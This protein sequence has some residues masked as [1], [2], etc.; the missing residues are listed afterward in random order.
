[1]AF[2]PIDSNT[3]KVGDPITSDTITLIKNNFDDHELRI[4]SLATS[5]GTVFIINGDVSF[6]G[7]NISNPSIFYYKAR[8]DFSINDFRVQL[9]TK[10]GLT[11]GD[12]VFD[13][14][15]SNDTNDSNFSTVLSSSLSIS[16]LS[17]SNYSEHIASLNPSLND[18]L[19]GQVLRIKVT[20]IPSNF[21]GSVLI[22]IGAQ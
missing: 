9:F 19:T 13:L 7:F 3:I 12:L 4:N 8:Q 14:Q 22:S 6:V 20:N 15:K 11:S 21:S 16:F 2:S 17:A 18:V 5:G 1:M 10:Q